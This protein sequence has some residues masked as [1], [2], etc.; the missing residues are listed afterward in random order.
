MHSLWFVQWDFTRWDHLGNLGRVSGS[1]LVMI[2]VR[3]HKY[4]ICMSIRM[5]S[6]KLATINVIGRPCICFPLSIKLSTG[7]KSV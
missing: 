3:S 7:F 6:I 2:S 1:G 5:Y 4:M